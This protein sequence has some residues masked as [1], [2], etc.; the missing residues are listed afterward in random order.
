MNKD[1]DF[2]ASGERKQTLNDSFYIYGLPMVSGEPDN[3]TK[4][5]SVCSDLE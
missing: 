2:L 5:R 1:D 3:V 4:A